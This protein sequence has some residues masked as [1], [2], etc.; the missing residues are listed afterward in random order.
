MENSNFKHRPRKHL[1]LVQV[2]TGDGKGKTTAALG[3]VVRAVGHKYK[4]IIIQFMK[5]QIRYGETELPKYLPNFE[6][7]QFG[8]PTFVKKGDP[9][10]EDVRLAKEGLEFAERALSNGDYDIVVMDEITVAV[11]Y[12]LLNVND[13]LNVVKDKAK[14]TEVILTGRY[15]PKEFLEIADLVSEI[16]EI[17]HP[18]QKGIQARE[19]VEY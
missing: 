4:V 7:H 9:S 5:G 6:L 8:L 15:A 14:H 12:G 18:Y 3:E 16:K 11:D 2:F 13:V 10:P 1:G 19:G 17:K